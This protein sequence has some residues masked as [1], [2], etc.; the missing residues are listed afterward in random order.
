[1]L[2]SA[3]IKAE[4]DKEMKE[5]QQRNIKWT[6]YYHGRCLTAVVAAKDAGDACSATPYHPAC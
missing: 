2:L 5:E 4:L 1:M 3:E 6:L